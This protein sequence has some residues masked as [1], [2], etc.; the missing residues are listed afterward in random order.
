MSLKCSVTRISWNEPAGTLPTIRAGFSKSLK[1]ASI[2]RPNN[3]LQM[4]VWL[5]QI[6]TDRV[7]LHFLSQNKLT[8]ITSQKERQI[9]LCV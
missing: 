8:F 2:S 5:Q 7:S 1:Y 9:Y 3:N 6:E 4:L